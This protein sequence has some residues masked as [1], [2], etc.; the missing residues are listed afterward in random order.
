MLDY[1]EAEIKLLVDYLNRVC[2]SL[3]DLN[4]DL[5]NWHLVQDRTLSLIKR[6]A[7][8]KQTRALVVAKIDRNQTGPSESDNTQASIEV[9]S[10]SVSSQPD[11]SNIQVLF[12]EKVEYMGSTAQTIAFLKRESYSTLDLSQASEQ[13]IEKMLDSSLSSQAV[14]PSSDA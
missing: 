10:D 13:D 14:Q 9:V 2:S 4:K 7:E 5:L 12:S 8:D 1:G 6:F 3:L 11:G